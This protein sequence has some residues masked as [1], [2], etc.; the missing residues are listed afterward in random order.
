MADFKT[1]IDDLT[2]FASTD[3][4]ALNDWLSA[5]S[6]SVINILPVNKLERV[7]SNE[8]FTNNIDV[9]GKKILAVVRKDDNHASK[10]YTP[11]R[12]LPPSMMGRVS[13][14]N[15]MEAASESDPAYIMQNDVLNTYPG[16][17]ASN[18]SRVVFINSS[19]T[20]SSTD[21]A[22]SNFPDEAEES[23]VLYAAR[24]AL[25]RLMND[26]QSND[27]IDHA[28]T[29]ALALMNAEIDDVV[30]DTTGSLKLAK[31]QIGAF[32]T[33]IADIDDTTELFDNTNKRF[34]VVRDALVKAKDIIDNDGF[35]SNLDVTDFMGDVDTALGKIN[36]H[37]IDEEAILTDDPTSGAINTALT[38]I[39]T[40][41]D[42]AATAAGK[43]ITSDESVFGDEDTFLTNNS[44]LTRVKDAL[45]KAQ[46]TITGDQPSS[47]TDA[48]GAQAEEDTELVASA[49]SIAQ[50]EITRAQTHLAEWTSIGDMRVKE[51]QAAL[52]EADG[53][54]KEVQARLAYASSYIAAANART[55]EGS[56]RIAQANLGV[57]VAQQELQR[58]NIAIA[59]VNSLMASYQLELQSVAPYMSE[60]SGK[61][62]AAAQYGQEVQ[63]RLTRDQAKYQWYTQQYAQVD[64]RYK[65]QI[66]TLQGA[67]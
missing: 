27:L 60:V 19:M 14:T 10:I 50:T 59:E 40:A 66:Q 45:D 26:L 13:D 48:R 38:A 37:L 6:R 43:F 32:V 65:E 9:E 7:A 67:L 20:V 35:G 15:Y 58:A 63:A 22:I 21:S 18:D 33:S 8:N 64:A 53:F 30:H 5:G 31:D 2:G 55:Q 4:T 46:E 3:D 56:S 39:K 34:T 41:V 62:A 29:G 47:T 16:S 25:E 42:Q 52:N 24:N 61:L 1:R 28:S 51:V 36:A 49:L 54:A 44:Q 12:K 11:C 17:N 57:A 23:V